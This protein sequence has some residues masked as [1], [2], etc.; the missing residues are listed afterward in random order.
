MKNIISLKR[1]ENTTLRLGGV[2][3]NWHM[4]WADDDIQ[5]VSM[6]DGTGFHGS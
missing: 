4:S 5:Y 6:C 2:G 3:D 1:L